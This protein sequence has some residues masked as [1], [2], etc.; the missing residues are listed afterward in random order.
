MRIKYKKLKLNTAIRFEDI[1]H[2]KETAKQKIKM[3]NHRI[4]K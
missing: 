4:V 2:I 3:K 1:I